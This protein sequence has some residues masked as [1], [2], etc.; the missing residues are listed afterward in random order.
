MFQRGDV[1]RVVSP[2]WLED[3]IGIVT[4]F[5]PQ[6]QNQVAISIFALGAKASEAWYGTYGD[7]WLPSVCLEYV[8]HAEG[9]E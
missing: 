2:Y 7:I 6:E 8:C 1:V 3:S 5:L 9:V 4:Y